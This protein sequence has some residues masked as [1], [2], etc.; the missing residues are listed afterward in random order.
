MKLSSILRTLKKSNWQM[1]E[2]WNNEK[3]KF[4]FA[5][6]LMHKIGSA[7]YYNKI[8]GNHFDLMSINDNPRY[9]FSYKKKLA[10]EFLVDLY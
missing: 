5:G 8:C 10:L 7:E 6:Y 1:G 3:T 9:S 2:L 4:C